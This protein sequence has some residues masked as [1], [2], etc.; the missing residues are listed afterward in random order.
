MLEGEFGKMVISRGKSHN[1]L[2]M[3]IEF[4]PDGRA[5]LQMKGY[6]E[7]AIKLYNKRLKPAKTPARK[8]IFT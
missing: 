8:N 7:K 3:D 1:F 5:K 2:G 4:Q 6:L